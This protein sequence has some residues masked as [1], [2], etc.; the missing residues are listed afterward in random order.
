MDAAALYV[1]KEVYSNCIFSLFNDKEAFDARFVSQSFLELCES[2][3]KD[4]YASKNGRFDGDYS[5][6]D[7]KMPV[8]Y[9][10]YICTKHRFESINLSDTPY[11]TDSVLMGLSSNKSLKDLNVSGCVGFGANSV[12]EISSCVSL[13]RLNLKGLLNDFKNVIFNLPNL[14]VL[15]LRF[16]SVDDDFLKNIC[17]SLKK[18]EDLNL[19]GCEG[20]T[21]DGVRNFINLKSLKTLNLAWTNFDVMDGAAEVI[22]ALKSKKNLNL[23]LM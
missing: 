21:V 16:F 19:N 4:I 10:V 2:R 8:K 6:G 18:L 3:I 20:V 15:N 1:P 12:K 14:K 22:D 17:E 23:I 13:E 5:D 11:I 9:F 7:I